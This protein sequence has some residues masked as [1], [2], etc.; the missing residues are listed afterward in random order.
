MRGIELLII[1]P[2][3]LQ[4]RLGGNALKFQ[5]VCPQNGTL[6]GLDE[7]PRKKTNAPPTV[8]CVEGRRR[9][10]VD[11][12]DFENVCCTTDWQIDYGGR[13]ST[14][15][16][17]LTSERRAC[18]PY[19][20]LTH[21]SEVGDG[22]RATNDTAVPCG[23]LGASSIM[24]WASRK[25]GVYLCVSG[26]SA[27]AL[28][29]LLADRRKGVHGAQFLVERSEGGRA[30]PQHRLTD[31]SWEDAS[32]KGDLERAGALLASTLTDSQFDNNVGFFRYALY[33]RQWVEP[34]RKKNTR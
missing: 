32:V 11:E 29:H 1:A 34:V 10:A 5:V 14:K 22:R 26:A 31:H 18:L 2:S 25:A 6:R 19:H 17:A 30:L 8:A 15:R 13:T 21:R 12:A 7:G 16:K 27:F 23:A 28:C 3:G 33:G 24:R 20:S 4:S 9:R